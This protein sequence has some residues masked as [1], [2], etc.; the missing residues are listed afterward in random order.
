[1]VS[2][3][4]NLVK[5]SSTMRISSYFVPCL[6]TVGQQGLSGQKW[7]TALKSSGKS[8]GEWCGNKQ[9]PEKKGEIQPV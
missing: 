1:M 8:N 9:R 3:K 5:S 7:K 4:E 6:N 2:A